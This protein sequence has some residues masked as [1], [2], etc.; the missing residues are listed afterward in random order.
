MGKLMTNA[1]GYINLIDLFNL[2]M[3]ASL[4]LAE[5]PDN[6]NAPGVRSSLI[7]TADREKPHEA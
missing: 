4:W 2:R 5:N 1:M 7:A 3:A 6:P